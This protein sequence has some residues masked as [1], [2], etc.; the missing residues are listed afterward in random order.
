MTNHALGSVYFNAR[1][2]REDLLDRPHLGNVA[3]QRAGGMRIDVVHLLAAWNVIMHTLSSS[4]ARGIL[5]CHKDGSI[6]T[7][8]QATEA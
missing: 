6:D 4:P 8:G 3:D 1:H 5:Q 7:V 2:V